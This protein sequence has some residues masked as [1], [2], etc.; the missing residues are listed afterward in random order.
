MSIIETHEVDTVV[1]NYTVEF[2][3]SEG[4]PIPDIC[5]D[6]TT[7]VIPGSRGYHEYV[8]RGDFA[9]WACDMMEGDALSCDTVHI[10]DMLVEKGARGIR[11]IFRSSYQGDLTSVAVEPHPGWN[12]VREP[13]GR[14]W[15]IAGFAFIGPEIVIGE[16]PDASLYPGTDLSETV[17]FY[18]E[19]YAA[20]QSG[21]V[22]EYVTIGP[23]G[24]EVDTCCF[25]YGLEAERESVLDM[26]RIGIG[27][28]AKEMR[29]EQARE[30]ARNTRFIGGGLLGD[31][32]RHWGLKSA[33]NLPGLGST[34]TPQPAIIGQGPE[35][36][37][38]VVDVFENADHS[39]TVTIGTAD[40]TTVHVRP[41]AHNNGRIDYRSAAPVPAS[42]V[43][44]E[45]S[46]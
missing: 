9:R 4:A 40:G 14:S 38:F 34:Q 36:A 12:E 10:V 18:V 13:N 39:I 41:S 44:R 3:T 35:G 26:A 23:D 2:H 11:A 21:D 8:T 28:H 46:A 25:F 5:G 17:R 29:A 37:A 42:T 30:Q 45:T 22:F 6:V 15:D 19:R 20:W 24:R 32:G 7:V 1:G 27:A 33:P 43:A 31:G 16:G